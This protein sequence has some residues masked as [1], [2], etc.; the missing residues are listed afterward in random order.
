M[1]RREFLAASLL[2]QTGAAG[3]A[4][5]WVASRP[6]LYFDR[7]TIERIRM[8]IRTDA[9]LETVWKALLSRAERHLKSEL[10][11][12]RVA[13]EGGG[14]HA[15][16]GRPA[17]QVS[18]MGMTLGLAWQ[19]TGEKRFAEKLRE[20][21]LYYGQYVRWG[22]Q[23]LAD[24]I[25]PW[26][27]ELNTARFCYGYGVG[28]DAIHDFLS[29]ADRKAIAG[30]LVR[31]GILPTLDDWILPEKRIHALDSMGHN[32][33]SV[34]VAMAGVAALALLGDEPRAPEWVDRVARGLDLWFEYRGNVLQNKPVNFDREGAFYESVNYAN[35]ALSEYLRFRLAYNSVFP[36]RPLPRHTGLERAAE[37]FLHTLYPTSSSYL[38]VNFG[39]SSLRSSAAHTMRLLAAAGFHHPALG[40]YLKKTDAG[41]R[42]PFLLFEDQEFSSSRPRL[43]LSVLYPDIGWATLRSSWDDDATMLAVKS[44]F[45][46]NHAHADAG[47]FMLFHAG[48]PLII[49]SGSCNYSRREYSAYYLQSRAHN[50]VLYEGRGQEPEELR[51]GSKHPGRLHSLLDGLG[52]KYVYADATGPTARYFSR[53]YRHWLWIEGVILIFDDLL[54]YESGRLDW[55]LHYGG[56]AE[57][58][59]DGALLRNGN[60]EAAV[61][62]LFPERIEARQEPGLAPARP[63]EKITYLAFS[64]AVSSREQKFVV[65][66][67]P[68]PNERSALPSVESL[69]GPEVMGARI[70]H[71]REITS[72]YLN[73]QADG[74]RMHVNTNNI[75]EG[76]DTDAYLLATTRPVDADPADP[77]AVTRFFVSCGS[78]VR[79]NDRVLL[80]SL[81]KVDA[82]W[83]PA[84][85]TEVLIRGQEAIE[86][87]LG[88]KDRPASLAV[89]GKQQRFWYLAK[90]RLVRFRTSGKQG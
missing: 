88:V 4:A 15:N 3:S 79:R 81:S 68:Y 19:V 38:T 60:A 87:C 6:R 59:P 20:A 52:L 22:G 86:A 45:T 53:N 76:W 23:G 72:V 71:G 7:K 35:Y 30:S 62:F 51:R 47:S 78:Y 75:I 27:S 39:D 50:V 17:G 29:P 42:D 74:R 36:R 66:I 48:Q 77:D 9:R 5:P 32:W 80:D 67:V 40:W 82:V 46:W 34:C 61:R 90:D 1:Q 31:L 24:R 83:R 56:S 26:H 11:P 16:Y 33:W 43:P 14:Q 18:D 70:R 73:L 64:P 55:L 49:D 58:T 65:A 21:L 54:A 2:S 69:H 57:R 25:P 63:D 84:P 28:Y 8:R 13:E 41:P 85:K 10:A 44:G 37:F 89:N 12:E